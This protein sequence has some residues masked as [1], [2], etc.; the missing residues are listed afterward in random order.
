MAIL[1]IDYESHHHRN[2]L[3]PLLDFR[4]TCLLAHLGHV[5]LRPALLDYEEANTTYDQV[6]IRPLRHWQEDTLRMIG[7]I[8][9]PLVTTVVRVE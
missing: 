3:H 7:D 5:F 8:A 1:V 2:F 9:F 6:Q 4:C